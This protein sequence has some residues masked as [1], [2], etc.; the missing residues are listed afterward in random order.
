MDAVSVLKKLSEPDC[1]INDIVEFNEMEEVK[2]NI[3][4]E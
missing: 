4:E 2:K 1:N 3:Q